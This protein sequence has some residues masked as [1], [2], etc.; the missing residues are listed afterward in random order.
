MDNRVSNV[1]TSAI[2]FFQIWVEQRT[3]QDKK[4]NQQICGRF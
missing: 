4:D 3:K 2:Y 1:P